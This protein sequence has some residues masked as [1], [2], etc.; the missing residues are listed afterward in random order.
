M[1]PSRQN[2]REQEG[3]HRPELKSCRKVGFSECGSRGLTVTQLPTESVLYVLI[4]VETYGALNLRA[5]SPLLT[6]VN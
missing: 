1:F 4:R 5:D 2:L 3:V 6:K